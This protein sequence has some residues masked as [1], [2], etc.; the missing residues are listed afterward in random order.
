MIDIT[1]HL[2]QLDG[3][4]LLIFLTFNEGWEERLAYCLVSFFRFLF[5]ISALGE[6]NLAWTFFFHYFYSSRGVL[7][8]IR[9]KIGR[10]EAVPLLIDLSV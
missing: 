1:T 8:G 2:N 5:S 10:S 6:R 4:F 9:K 7:R 3:D